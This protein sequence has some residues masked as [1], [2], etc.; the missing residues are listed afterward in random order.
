MN[1]LSLLD[2]PRPGRLVSKVVH[3]N[4][5]VFLV[6]WRSDFLPP[7]LEPLLYLAAIGFG[8][9]L[10]IDN[11]EG[12]P[13]V[14]WFAPALVAMMAMNTSFFECAYGSYVRMVIQKTYDAMVATPVSL[15]D[16]VAG[17]LVWGA[18]KSVI[19][20]LIVLLVLL[21]LG[22]A[23]SPLILFS[24]PVVFIAAFSFASVGV[25][26][27]SLARGFDAFNYPMYLYITPMFFLSGTFIP[28]SLFDGGQAFQFIA[29]TLPLTHAV[30]ITRSLSLGHFGSTEA[31]SLA[32]LLFVGFVLSVISINAMRRRLVK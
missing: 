15:D 27:S 25:L 13:Y 30:L 10:F 20:A 19:N 16:V 12:V 3:R 21:V 24:L 23:E 11:I 14:D 9:G 29:Y 8:L 22:L 18:V 5:D 1:L 4:A 26:T 6:G 31:A 7:L 28:L 2:R 32:W 17:E